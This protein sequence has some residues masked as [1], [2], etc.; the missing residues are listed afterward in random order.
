MPL[1]TDPVN[2]ASTLPGNPP[3]RPPCPVPHVFG[4]GPS[5]WVALHAPCT[6]PGPA[7][8]NR[9]LVS[10]MLHAILVVWS[11]PCLCL[12]VSPRSLLL[13]TD[14]Y[15]AATCSLFPR[16]VEIIMQAMHH[17]A[18]QPMFLPRRCTCYL[19][20]F[21]HESCICSP[22]F[23]PTIRLHAPCPCTLLIALALR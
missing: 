17:W 3:L 10:R 9:E 7:A 1:T 8:T 16:P 23:L 4:S 2:P 20:I 18:M 11:K 14:S 15:I 12:R 22:V 6:S 19:S 21:C 13:M 5:A